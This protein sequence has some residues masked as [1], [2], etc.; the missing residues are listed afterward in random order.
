MHLLLTV[1]I[2]THFTKCTTVLKNGL[3]VYQGIDDDTSKY[4]YVVQI[5][6]LR[7]CTGSLLTA[8]WVITAAHCCVKQAELIQYG[9]TSIP[10]DQ[11]NS[12][13]KVL[14]MVPH[15]RYREGIFA[16]IDI[17]LMFVSPVAMNKYA[18]L[19][20]VDYVT[21]TGVA[22]E[23]AGH[24]LTFLPKKRTK[25]LAQKYRNFQL[26]SAVKIGEAVVSPCPFKAKGFICISPK[27]SIRQ[28]TTP[29]DSG[30]PLMVESKIVGL[31]SSA[32]RDD[33][34]S[35]DRFFTPISTHF[36]WINSVMSSKSEE[37]K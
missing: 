21:L 8:N 35:T 12:T 28:L 25:N 2:T 30:G 4:P 33:Y 37:Q 32:N 9:N 29:G 3:R 27:C 5:Q 19:S 6:P 18:R 15:P 16:P 36:S 22:V 23:Y 11:S 20:A 7:L 1:L 34:Q 17:G 14:K 13:S 26:K 24:G 10:L 31:V